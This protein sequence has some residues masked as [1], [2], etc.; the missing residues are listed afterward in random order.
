MEARL[1]AD[2]SAWRARVYLAVRASTP[3]P[4][5]NKE[6]SEA[7]V[8]TAHR[9]VRLDLVWRASVHTSRPRMEVDRMGWEIN[10]LVGVGQA[11]C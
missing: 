11:V 10:G 8:G 1:R 9:A 2:A 6:K 3:A 5:W 4:R 7:Q